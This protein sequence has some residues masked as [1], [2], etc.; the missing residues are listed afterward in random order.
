MVERVPRRARAASYNGD[1]DSVGF[2]L[3]TGV[4]PGVAALAFV[5][6]WM[7]ENCSAK[8][9][10]FGHPALHSLTK[11]DIRWIDIASPDPRSAM[12]AALEAPEVRR[13]YSLGADFFGNAVA[14]VVSAEPQLLPAGDARYCA[15]SLWSRVLGIEDDLCAVDWT[16][17][18]LVDG[19]DI[20]LVPGRS[21]AAIWADHEWPEDSWLEL[22]AHPALANISVGVLT[23][24]DCVAAI[25]LARLPNIQVVPEDL[26]LTTLA[27]VLQGV[28]AVVATDEGISTFATILGRPTVL[29]ESAHSRPGWVSRPGCLHHVHPQDGGPLASVTA[30]AVADILNKIQVHLTY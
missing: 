6:A 19:P 23:F 5:E 10:V 30:G 21:T 24:S 12:K 2:V 16:A 13:C 7:S 17:E 28:R 25:E 15:F 29:I 8:V 9:T 27:G 18:S 20:L 14:S 26:P 4:A 1:M 3:P 11:R 22:A